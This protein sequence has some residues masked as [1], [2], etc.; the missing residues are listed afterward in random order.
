MVEFVQQRATI[1]SEVYCEIL[2]NCVSPLRNK[3][4]VVLT[5]GV[6]LLHD[7]V[8]P[9]TAA[10]TRALLEHFNWDLCDHPP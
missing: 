8:Q 2:K 5:S 7:N 6:V 10:R 4:R 3:T 9:H 1:T